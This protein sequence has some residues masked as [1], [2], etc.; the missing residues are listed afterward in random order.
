MYYFKFCLQNSVGDKSA[1]FPI[2]SGLLINVRLG[3][4]RFLPWMHQ[5]P[6][7]ELEEL[8]VIPH[9]GLRRSIILSLRKEL[10]KE[11]IGLAFGKSYIFLHTFG[12]SLI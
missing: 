11:K 9:G 7:T 10:T 6:V 3:E 2:I 4:E 5:V 1:S 8:E 12:G